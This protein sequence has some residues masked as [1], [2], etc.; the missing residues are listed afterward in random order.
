MDARTGSSSAQS[1]DR[2]IVITK[3]VDAP[4]ELV[5]SAMT[6]PAHLVQW[7]GPCGF[8]NRVEK[9]DLRPGGEWKYLMRGPDGTDY[10]NSSVFREVV[11]P[12]RIVFHHGGGKKDHPGPNFLATWTFEALGSKTRVT[13]HILFPS[14]HDRDTVIREY[15]AMEGGKQTLERLGEFLAKPPVI[16]TVPLDG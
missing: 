12:E 16:S 5:W 6:D 2:E 8:T 11:K 7:W 9:M 1:A 3:I 13:I 10:P 14:A 4:R 15:G